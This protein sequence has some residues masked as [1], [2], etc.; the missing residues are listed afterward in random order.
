MSRLREA[1]LEFARKL[2]LAADLIDSTLHP[3]HH[4]FLLAALTSE[5]RTDLVDALREQAERLEAE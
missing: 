3:S 4:R 5:D 1:E 2:K